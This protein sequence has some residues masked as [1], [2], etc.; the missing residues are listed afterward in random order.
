MVKNFKMQA[1]IKIA[2]GGILLIS[3]IWGYLPIPKHMNEYTFLSNTIE[4]FV[5]L[6]SG[7]LLVTKQKHIPPIVDLCLVIL[8]F[9]MLG[10]CIT[11]YQIFG[12]SG[13]YLFLH[14]INPIL[15]LLH[16]V[17]VTEKRKIKN[18][19]H[20]LSVLILPAVYMIFLFSFG[21]LTN[22]FIYPVFDINKLGLFNVIVFVL[23]VGVFFLGIA[24][25]MYFIDRKIGRQG[26]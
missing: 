6:Y 8:A 3:V 15:L 12:F 18:A 9:I 11:N 2:I 20:V 21:F 13:A 7:I 19:K 1:I 26:K 10:I 17:F 5:L 16:W 25:I 4:G 24:Y 23:I 14:V 22:D